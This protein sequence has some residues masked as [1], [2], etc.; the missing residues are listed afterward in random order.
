MERYSHAMSKSKPQKTRRPRLETL[1]APKTFQLWVPCMGAPRLKRDA[2]H[3]PRAT[4]PTTIWLAAKTALCT[5]SVL[6]SLCSNAAD[7]ASAPKPPKNTTWGERMEGI[8]GR[9]PEHAHAPR[10]TNSYNTAKLMTQPT[11]ALRTPPPRTAKSAIAQ[12]HARFKSKLLRCVFGLQLDAPLQGRVL[13]GAVLSSPV[14]ALQSSILPLLHCNSRCCR[15]S[16]HVVEHALQGPTIHLHPLALKHASV[17]T[18]CSDA[19]CWQSLWAPLA[20]DTSRVLTPALHSA[21]AVHEDHAEVHSQS[22]ISVHGSS[23]SG[24]VEL[25]KQSSGLPFAHDTFRVLVPV[26]QVVEQADQL[27]TSHLQPVTS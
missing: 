5:S 17:K 9:P 26:P 23:A 6:A 20:Q 27:P 3:K 1:Q 24:R 10:W 4:S 2:N 16:P 13:L 15:P 7:M 8:R 11:S 22:I 14:G 21:A 12:G 19:V 18:A 25:A